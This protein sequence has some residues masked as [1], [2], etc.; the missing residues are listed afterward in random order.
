MTQVS[1]DILESV[2]LIIIG[3]STGNERVAQSTI[4][5]C[6]LNEYSRLLG[7]NLVT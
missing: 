6:H 1:A 3:A 2:H 5:V 4:A 7:S